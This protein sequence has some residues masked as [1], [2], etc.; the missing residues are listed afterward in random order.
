[1]PEYL[2]PGVYPEEIERGPGSLLSL[3]TS[4]AG[5]LGPTEIGPVSPRLITSMNSF[6]KIYG[7]FL[8]NSFLAY[9][10]RGFFENGGENKRCFVARIASI[11][12]GTATKD[13]MI[14][15]NKLKIQAI[16]PGRWGGRIYY[17]VEPASTKKE[18]LFKLTLIYFE[19]GEEPDTSEKF[20]VSGTS[21]TPRFTP[22][23]TSHFIRNFIKGRKEKYIVDGPYNELSLSASSRD[24]YKMEVNGV[25]NLVLVSDDFPRGTSISTTS[26]IPITKFIVTHWKDQSLLTN[27]KD[28]ENF[29]DFLGTYFAGW[30]S[31]ATMAKDSANPKKIINI[32]KDGGSEPSA[33][34]EYNDSDPENPTLA[35]K[36]GGRLIYQFFIDKDTS[37]LDVFAITI[38]PLDY[39]KKP[40]TDELVQDNEIAI[41]DYQGIKHSVWDPD[42]TTDPLTN[43][44]KVE[45]TGLQGFEQIDE[46]SLVCAP[47]QASDSSS[48]I[49]NAI[50]D[51]CE[52][53]KDR[54]AIVQATRSQS[55]T[56]DTFTIDRESKFAAIYM[57]WIWVSDPLTK[58]GKGNLL[59]P[60][61]GHVAGIY[62]R[63]DE[64]GVHKAPAN[65][66]VR[67][68][69]NLQI[70]LT[71]E[72]QAI[73]NPRCINVIRSISGQGIK[74]WGARTTS[75]DPSWIYINT[76]RVIAHVFKTARRSLVP[77]VF[78]PNNERL[79]A[80]IVSV[81]TPFLTGLRLSGAL[82]GTKDEDA[83]KIR[84]DRTTMTQDDIDNGRLIVVIALALTKPAEFVILRVAQTREGAAIEEL[85]GGA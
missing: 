67:G 3:S 71:S 81:I 26:K 68:A 17:K 44:N 51:H 6:N 57:P 65:E 1:L 20:P 23:P 78:M 62:A 76:R 31:K 8:E 10:V 58:S 75:S 21:S 48:E 37:N 77:F 80:R 18:G 33:S 43:T 39:P 82:M 9:A 40:T 69:G 7:G 59:I 74:V 61:G 35:L 36:V 56:F 25:S 45:Y 49:K 66:V 34:I 63:S 13:I 2:T 41:S 79:W 28:R 29:L 24:Y 64:I 16:G 15:T 38:E 11:K 14:G 73:M 27:K 30:M 72:D 46:I 12:D 83:F 42:A 50:I 70:Q 84:C 55:N 47:D 5:F 22:D 54:F 85:L 19:D 60:P 53:M 32:T 4:T 52:K